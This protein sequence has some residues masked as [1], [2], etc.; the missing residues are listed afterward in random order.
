MFNKNVKKL[1]TLLLLALS[2]TL[3]G[4]DL[5]DNDDDDKPETIINIDGNALKGIL[6]GA[7]VNLYHHTDI[8][9]PLL[10]TTT[11]SNGDYTLTGSLDVNGVYLVTVTANGSTTMI[12]DVE[13]C[14]TAESLI[15]F[16][17]TVPSSALVGVE[18]SNVTYIDTTAD[19][20]SVT[21]P[22]NAVTTIATELYVSNL[23]ATNPDLAAITASD[24]TASQTAV[25]KTVAAMFGVDVSADTNVFTLELP[26]LND[27]TETAA[28]GASE[29]GFA[30]INAAFSTAAGTSIATSIETIIDTSVALAETSS[31]DSNYEDVANAWIAVQDVLLDE[32]VAVSNNPEI[33]L[34][35]E[36]AEAVA[37][38]VNAANEGVNLE[39]IETTNNNAKD[40]VGD[41]TGATGAGA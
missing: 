24:F 31:E 15:G 30:I 38:I 14:G 25:T 39:E 37:E 35:E 6:I 18:L 5:F 32:A 34:S 26:N 33:T 7:D 10:T 3:T 1:S 4:C 27:S 13:N 23:E 16:G 20:V 28:A 17:E 12:C 2:F 36:A 19:L 9:I 29:S 41:P 22:V 40:I 11:D 8:S 21:V